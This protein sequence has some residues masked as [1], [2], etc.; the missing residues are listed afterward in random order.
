[1]D[2]K[3][4]DKFLKICRKHGVSEI[5]FDNTSVKFGEMPAQNRKYQADLDE[6]EVDELTEEQMTFL[7]VQSGN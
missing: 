1:M 4:L 6:T 5:I 3:E 2:A 7:H